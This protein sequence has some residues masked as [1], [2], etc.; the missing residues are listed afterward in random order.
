MTHNNMNINIDMDN[1]RVGQSILI[2]TVLENLQ[3]T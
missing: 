3:H 2:F 1:I